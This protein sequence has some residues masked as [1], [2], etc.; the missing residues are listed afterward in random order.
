MAKVIGIGLAAV[1]A[2]AL[3]GCGKPSGDGTA[4][5]SAAAE[6]PVNASAGSGKADAPI[7]AGLQNSGEHGTLANAVKA[8]GLTQTFSGTQPYTVFAP[9]DAAFQ[10]LPTGTVE[11]LMAADAKGRLVSLITGHMVQGFVT[12]A[13]LGKAIDRGKGK[14][15]LATLGGGT[16]T[17]TRSGGNIAVADS[18]GGQ[19]TITHADLNQSNGI[20]HSIDT[21]LGAQ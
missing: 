4:N 1:G 8:A 19:G 16:L 15:Q 14:A 18:K 6:P 12:S 7:L 17:F 10:K 21:V 3:A 9:T 20:V 13:D 5:N 2:L 11:G